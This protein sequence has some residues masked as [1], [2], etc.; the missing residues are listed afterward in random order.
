[1]P[2]HDEMD[3]LLD[4][5]LST[6]ATPRPGLEDR[7]LRSLASTRAIDSARRPFRFPRRWLPWAIAV[8]I[9]AAIALL[10]LLTRGTPAPPRNYAQSVP[11]FQRPAAPLER[12]QS[13]SVRAPSRAVHPVRRQAKAAPEIAIRRDLPKQNIFPSPQPLSS[14]EQALV[15]LAQAPESVRQSLIEAQAPDGPITI[16][17]IQIQPLK[18]PDPGQN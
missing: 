13:S 17:A 11:Q 8:P 12:P 16:S 3:R 1:M 15:A 18:M 5:A 14:D 6:Y 10:F 7:V 2:D 9:A 4:S